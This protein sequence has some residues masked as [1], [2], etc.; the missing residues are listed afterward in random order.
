MKRQP[1]KA[2]ADIDRV[3]A[4]EPQ[5]RPEGYFQVIMRAVIKVDFVPRLQTQADRAPESLDP[6][7]G[8]HG[9]RVSP[10]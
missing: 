10:V 2:A 6:A 5:G 7:A 9:K 4:L 3:P 8:I 1:G